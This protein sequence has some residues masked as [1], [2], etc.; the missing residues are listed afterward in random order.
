MKVNNETEPLY[1]KSVDKKVKAACR[2]L[3]IDISETVRK[4]L[5]SAV[6]RKL[7][8]QAWARRGGGKSAAPET[9]IRVRGLNRWEEGRYR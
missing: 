9:A 8:K 1:V 6:I 3:D 5:K 4:A 2:E 7:G